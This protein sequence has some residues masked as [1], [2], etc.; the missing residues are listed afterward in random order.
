M[1]KAQPAAPARKKSKTGEKLRVRNTSQKQT[2]ALKTKDA[3][4][5]QVMHQT[6][7]ELLDKIDQK[8]NMLIH[9][10][11]RVENGI[12]E[13]LDELRETEGIVETEHFE[14]QA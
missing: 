1:K 13:I 5:K 11:D 9:R 12:G 10:L 4:I 7:T 3:E 14:G 8:I 2:F 6:K